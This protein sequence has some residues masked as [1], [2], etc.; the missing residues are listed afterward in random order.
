MNKKLN[1]FTLMELLIVIAILGILVTLLIPSL[2]KARE[3]SK[4]AV[5]M[6]N[7]SQI[8]TGLQTYMVQN[9]GRVPLQD[10][11]NNAKN[12]WTLAVD[13]IMTGNKPSRIHRTVSVTSPIWSSCP[14]RT[15]YREGYGI[16]DNAEN[17][18][19]GIF[20]NNWYRMLKDPLAKVQDPSSAGILSETHNENGRTDI[21]N[22]WFIALYAGHRVDVYDN[23]TKGESRDSVMHMNN[24]KMNT[25]TLDGAVHSK[26]WMHLTE[27]S[28]KFGSW[29]VDY[30]YFY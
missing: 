22:S 7:M 19:Y 3:V 6:S 9:S 28:D 16:T 2:S 11:A 10:S 15:Q 14:G 20:V 23:I 12:T 1:H 13:E 27:Y 21:G 4:V 30:N 8:Y 24:T 25:A 18:D 29:L 26:R 5:C 17:S